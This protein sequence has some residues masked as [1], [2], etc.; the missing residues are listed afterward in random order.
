MKFFSFAKPGAGVLPEKV[1]LTYFYDQHNKAKNVVYFIDPFAMYSPHRNEQYSF[2]EQPYHNTVLLA[3]LKNHFDWD[4]ISGYITSNLDLRRGPKPRPSYVCGTSPVITF[5]KSRLPN[6]ISQIYGG[7]L[8]RS[9]FNKYATDLGDLIN[10]AKEHNARVI[11]IIP[12]YLWWQQD[13]AR[14]ILITLLEQ[15]KVHHGIDFYDLSNS[16]PDLDRYADY[17]HLNCKGV[18]YFTEKFLKPILLK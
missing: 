6:E 13:P 3:L 11:L 1:Y 10:T 12:P 2:D 9:Q 17:D 14:K 8:N 15:Y 7:G 18:L 5:D 4:V 16:I